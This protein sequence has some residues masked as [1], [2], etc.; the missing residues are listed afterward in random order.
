MMLTPAS[1]TKRHRKAHVDFYVHARETSTTATQLPPWLRLAVGVPSSPAIYHKS[2]NTT[3][4]MPAISDVHVDAE[5]PPASSR[6]PSP[7][8]LC[9]FPHKLPRADA[10]K[11]PADACPSVLNS[12]FQCPKVEEG[13]LKDGRI[14]W[15][16]HWCGKW[17]S[18]RHATRALCHVTRAKM[19]KS[20]APCTGPIDP[21]S[22]RRCVCCGVID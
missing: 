22:H 2:A 8:I 18:R 10:N 3:R 7:R 1:D 6:S 15:T 19:K 11:G 20:I 9:S 17:F 12:V 16:C 4:P 5:A 21:E 14:G 13:A